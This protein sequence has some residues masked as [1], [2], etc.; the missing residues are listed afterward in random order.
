MT[1]ADW[2]KTVHQVPAGDNRPGTESQQ[3]TRTATIW[4]L[5]WTTHTAVAELWSLKG[6]AGFDLRYTIDG[7][8]REAQLFRGSDGGTKATL[9]ALDKKEELIGKHG[10]PPDLV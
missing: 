6:I 8:L 3:T 10:V 4:T 9:A 5:T 2:W 1:N 7:E